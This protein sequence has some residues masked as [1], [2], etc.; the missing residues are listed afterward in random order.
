MPGDDE[1]YEE[2]DEVTPLR[3]SLDADGIRFL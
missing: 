2:A 3:V 1:I